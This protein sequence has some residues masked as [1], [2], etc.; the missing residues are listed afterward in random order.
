MIHV[1]PRELWL[2]AQISS[3]H[4]FVTFLLKKQQKD[5][6]VGFVKQCKKEKMQIGK[7][8]QGEI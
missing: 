5:K 8:E 1:W 6:I 4:S 3:F 2:A 7:M